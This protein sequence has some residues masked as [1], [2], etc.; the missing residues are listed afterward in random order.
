MSIW[1]EDVAPKAVVTFKTK[2]EHDEY[3]QMQLKEANPRF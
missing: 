2:I 3:I 1:T